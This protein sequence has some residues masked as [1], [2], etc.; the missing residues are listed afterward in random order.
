MIYAVADLAEIRIYRNPSFLL[1]PNNYKDEREWVELIKETIETKDNPVRIGILDSGVNNDH[2]LLSPFISDE[3]CHNATLAPSKRDKI[4]HGTL[5]SGLVLF[6][7]LTDA[8][9]TPHAKTSVL[10]DLTSV[11]IMPGRDEETNMPEFYGV[12][13]ENSIRVAEE[14]GATIQC[15][16]IT[17]QGDT[18]GE[19]SSWS[20]AIDETLYNQGNPTSMLL[21]AAGNVREIMGVGYP[22]FNN[23]SQVEEPGQ[24]WNALTVGAYT[25]KCIISD[26]KYKGIN[27]IAPKH[28]LS[29]FSRTSMMWDKGI[30]K[31]E[32]LMEGGNA[33]YDGD[34]LSYSPDEINLVSTSAK[35]II[36]P[37]DII[38]ATSAATA[39]AA[40]LASKIKYYNS[41]LTPLSIRAL[42]VHSAEWTEEMKRQNTNEKGELDTH[43]LLHSCGYG[44]PVESKA[45]V[46][47]D[48]CPTFV[49]ESS[50]RALVESKSGKYKAGEMQIVELPWPKEVLESL[51]AES[52][53]LKITLSYYI[54]P[55]PGSRSRISKYSYPSVNLRFDLINATE[56]LTEFKRRV[57][58]ID[59]DGVR[60]TKNDTKRWQI[61]ISE[62]NQGS[63][64]SDYICRSA[65]E[66]ANCN[67][68]AIYPIVGWM[69]NIKYTEDVLVP[70]SLVVSIET[71]A[72]DI[73]ISIPIPVINE[74]PV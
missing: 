36:H 63:I 38:N 6:G 14:D 1:R 46:S 29:P 10:L 26:P 45:V 55:A 73:Y 15:S 54:K 27:P 19:P 4:N 39:L 40:R 3:R 33:I 13:A 51:G 5:L 42:M 64:V 17:S 44:V 53:R 37:F 61:G 74:I 25:D 12:V 49:L 31:P 56:N 68:L 32:I 59:T 7:D 22:D 62:R 34:G 24:S 72:T 28:S 23:L 43:A 20:A 50:L 21:L 66:I 48:N 69:K 2:P 65:S 71:E 9:Y 52:V 30:I 57:S 58:H 8:I 70:Y 67:V 18:D 60:K 11:K 35:H 47:T 41:S 16:A